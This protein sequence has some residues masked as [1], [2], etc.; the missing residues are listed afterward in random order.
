MPLE[1]LLG[2]EIGGKAFERLVSASGTADRKM[3]E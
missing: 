2:A 1:I 3:E